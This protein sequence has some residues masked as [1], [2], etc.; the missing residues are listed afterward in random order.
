MGVAER[1][2]LVDLLPLGLGRPGRERGTRALQQALLPALRGELP[3]ERGQRLLVSPRQRLDLAV[4]SQLAL[5]S[6]GEP[7][8]EGCGSTRQ[9]PSGIDDRG[10]LGSER[11]GAGAELG[12]LFVDRS[13]LLP[14][15][16]EFV[17]REPGEAGEN[18]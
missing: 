2:E 1:R 4:E 5:P 14:A 16:I 18:F 12:E 13:E 7:P 8:A 6:G 15:T 9:F 11:E 3:F 17:T 10:Q